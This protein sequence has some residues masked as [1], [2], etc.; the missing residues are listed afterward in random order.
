M[1]VCV[2]VCVYVS[3]VFICAAYSKSFNTTALVHKERILKFVLISVQPA[4]RGKAKS[5][6][7]RWM[8]YIQAGQLVTQ[9]FVNWVVTRFVFC[10]L[11]K[12]REPC[13]GPS[14][15]QIVKLS[16][17]PPHIECTRGAQPPD[18]FKDSCTF[19]AKSWSLFVC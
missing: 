5:F 9:F 12:K 8:I 13:M 15:V 1:C 4:G 10:L 16:N 19:L 6:Q 3:N 11:E 14:G 7:S 17:N 2:C 18:A